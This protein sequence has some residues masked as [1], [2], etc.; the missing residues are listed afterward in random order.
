MRQEQTLS[1][2]VWLASGPIAI[3]RP[4]AVLDAF[5]G[6]TVRVVRFVGPHRFY[7]AAGW[8]ARSGR[9]ASAYGSWWADEAALAR[10]GERLALYKGFLPPELLRLAWPAQF[11]AAA[12]LCEDWN[13]L[14]ELFVLDLPA[15]EELT[16]V[17][18]PAA[19]QPLRSRQDPARRDTRMLP[20]G[21][22]QVFF[23]RTR[24]L[25][26]VNPLWVRACPW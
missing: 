23:K 10:I 14:R 2:S 8:D 9:M 22:E 24:T 13:D 25:N 18:G 21:I 7:R 5:A 15:R 4:G 20:G 11:R 16:G 26:A 3:A 19:P 12:A 1:P 17:V 6:G